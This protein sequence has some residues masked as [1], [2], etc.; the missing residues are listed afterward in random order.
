MR[1]LCRLISQEPR[2]RRCR[3]DA[4]SRGGLHNGTSELAPPNRAC[5]L[6]V[7]S[8]APRSG[9]RPRARLVG[10]LGLCGHAEESDSLN[11]RWHGR[12]G[13][14]AS[15]T[16][17][18]TTCFHL[19]SLAACV[20][21]P[22]KIPKVPVPGRTSMA[23]CGIKVHFGKTSICLGSSARRVPPAPALC[24]HLVAVWTLI[25]PTSPLAEKSNAR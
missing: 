20:Q 10:Y 3:D 12:V 13:Q 25:S 4:P 21:T 14:S 7:Q 22:R 17:H 18:K 1:K 5:V 15:N 24:R 16:G 2:Q 23:Q 8:C 19:P 11:A 9:R 6:P